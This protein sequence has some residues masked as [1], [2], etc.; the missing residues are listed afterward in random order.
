LYVQNGVEYATDDVSGAVLDPAGVYAARGVEVDFFRSMGVYDYVPRSEQRLTG[1]KIIGTKWIDVNKGD[2]ENPRLRSRMV[3]KEFRTGPDDALYAS[4]PPLEA[5]RVVL[6]R[7]ATVTD[8][9]GEREIMVND[10]SRAY[11]YAKMTRPLYIEIPVEDPKAS[12][13]MLGR[14]RLCLYGTRDAALNWQHTLSEHLVENGFVRGTGHPSVFHHSSRDIWTLVHGDDYCSAGSPED[15]DWMESMLGKKYEIKSQRIGSGTTGAGNEKTPEGQVLNRVVRRTEH[16]YELEADLRHAEL[17]VEQ[18]GLQDA[19][20]VSTPGVD[21]PGSGRDE[22]QEPEEEPELPAAEAT[23]FRGIAARCNYLQPDRPD[24]QFAV[25]ECCRLMSRPTAR[26]W[27]MLKR[28]GRYLKGR[29]RLVWKFDW[30]S[31]IDVLD[32]HSDAN[33]A[34]CRVSRKSSSG[35]TIAIG[36]HLIRSYSKT[37]SVIAKSS[38]ESELYAVVRASAE[39][40]GILTLLADFGRPGLKASVGMDA[41]A[42]IGIAQRQGIGKLRHIEVDVLWLQEQQARRLLPLRKVPGPHNPSD[43]GT[44]NIAVALMDEYLN[45]L[46]LKVVEGRAAIAQQLHT[47]SVRPIVTKHEIQSGTDLHHPK[48]NPSSLRQSAAETR[49]VDSW[50]STGDGGRWRREH[51]SRR[52]ALFTPYKVAGGPDRETRMKRCRVTEG[53]YSDTGEGF[54]IVDDWMKPNNT[55][56]LLRCSWTGTTEYQEIPEYME[57][58]IIQ[59]KTGREHICG[60]VHS[61][62]LVARVESPEHRSP[63]NLQI[64][65]KESSDAARPAR[66]LLLPREDEHRPEYLLQQAT[67]AEIDTAEQRPEDE[68]AREHIHRAN[69]FHQA[70]NEPLL[71]LRNA[72]RSCVERILSFADCA[73]LSCTRCPDRTRVWGSTKPGRPDRHAARTH[74][75]CTGGWGRWRTYHAR[76]NARGSSRLPEKVIGVHRAARWPVGAR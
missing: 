33:W 13:D 25:K 71:M 7:A 15:L 32:I 45:R 8:S 18:L 68:Q 57:E 66:D 23:L 17:I 16:G 73:C 44:K 31:S 9:G 30:Q 36:S 47:I 21:P 64:L 2:S 67:A 28:V 12:P 56:R 19:K 6:S 48:Q 29:P 38:G 24:I 59:S 42:A 11:F 40:L 69:D 55:H 52:R 43:M 72:V 61:L 53:V 3:G 37:Q 4:T 5:L 46:N 58:A 75:R 14:L 39:G 62:S 76:P 63:A 35:G 60:G 41:S 26:A 54:R 50:S 20:A 10:V 65:S 70:L 51:R 27:E 34:G 1:G 74:D 49:G 22:D